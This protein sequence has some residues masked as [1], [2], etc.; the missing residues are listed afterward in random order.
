MK[1]YELQQKILGQKKNI[2][3]ND[4]MLHIEEAKPTRDEQC[5][6]PRAATSCLFQKST[7][8]IH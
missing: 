6:K 2:D 1:K 4:Q 8:L 5:T 3:E 7:L